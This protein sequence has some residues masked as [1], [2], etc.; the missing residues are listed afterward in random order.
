VADADRLLE[1]ARGVLAVVANRAM[2]TAADGGGGSAESM[3]LQDIARTD[4]GEDQ[5]RGHQGSG[6]IG[7]DPRCALGTR[8]R[9]DALRSQGGAGGGYG[10]RSH[11]RGHGV[12]RQRL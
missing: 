7:A 5:R 6:D 10:N 8:A 9:A 12:G 2:S 3:L 11:H 4:K 1:T